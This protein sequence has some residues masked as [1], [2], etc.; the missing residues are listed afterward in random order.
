VVV[1][2]VLQTQATELRPAAA[3]FHGPEVVLAVA[4]WQVAALR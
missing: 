1:V 3:I 2:A 4:G